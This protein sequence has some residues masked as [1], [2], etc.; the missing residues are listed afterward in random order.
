MRWYLLSSA[1]SIKVATSLLDSFPSFGTELSDEAPELQIPTIDTGSL[2]I[3][4]PGSSDVPVS[5][6]DALPIDPE[7]VPA[8]LAIG[9][10]SCLYQ[11]DTAEIKERIDKRADCK[12]PSATEKEAGTQDTPSLSRGYPR[13]VHT[14]EVLDPNDSDPET[15]PARKPRQKPPG[16]VPLHPQIDRVYENPFIADLTGRIKICKSRLMTLC[17]WGPIIKPMTTQMDIDNCQRC[18]HASFS[19]LTFHTPPPPFA[20]Y[21]RQAHG[22]GTDRNMSLGRTEPNFFTSYF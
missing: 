17:C 16:P 18:A 14:P 7:V 4:P 2:K 8:D 9:G 6:S 1:L 21:R 20:P 5:F 22:I 3:Y 15:K 11:R 10:S 13:P 12:A 19:L